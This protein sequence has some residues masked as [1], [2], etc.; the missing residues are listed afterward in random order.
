MFLKVHL[1][2]EEF[3]F[4]VPQSIN[5]PAPG[6]YLVGTTERR[7]GIFRPLINPF[8]YCLD[9]SLRLV[10]KGRRVNKVVLYLFASV[11]R[12]RS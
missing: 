4:K 6:P 10:P 3:Y 1:E 8:R 12:H 9:Q 5:D 2:A 11:L 7:L